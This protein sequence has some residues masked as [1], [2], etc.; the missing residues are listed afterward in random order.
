MNFQF[1]ELPEYNCN[2]NLIIDLKDKKEVDIVNVPILTFV[3]ATFIL[4]HF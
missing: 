2:Q 3:F 4:A 1:Q